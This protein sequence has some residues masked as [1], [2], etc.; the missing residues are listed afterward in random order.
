MGEFGNWVVYKI[1]RKRKATFK[2]ELSER[3]FKDH[4]ADIKDRNAG[5]FCHPESGS[6]IDPKKIYSGE[7]ED[8]AARV[9]QKAVTNWLDKKTL[10]ND[11]KYLGLPENMKGT[12]FGNLRA[13]S[14]MNLEKIRIELGELTDDEK[15]ILSIIRSVKMRF[16]HQTG[17]R[18]DKT[19]LIMMS[20]SLRQTEGRHRNHYHNN[21]LFYSVEF[22]HEFSNE[23]PLKTKQTSVDQGPIA[24]LLSKKEVESRPCLI[25][26]CDSYTRS[27]F[28][29]SFCSGFP[30]PGE[31]VRGLYKSY[32]ARTFF[33]PDH[34]LSAMGLYLIQGIRDFQKSNPSYADM[35]I[36]KI[37]TSSSENNNVQEVLNSLMEPEAKV[38]RMLKS[39]DFCK[40]QFR[41]Y[42]VSEAI[43]FQKMDEL[44]SYLNNKDDCV[45]MLAE[46]LEDEYA[47]GKCMEPVFKKI[48]SMVGREDL[49][50]IKEAYAKISK[51]SKPGK[52]ADLANYLC[53]EWNDD[54][55]ELLL[56]KG[57]VK[58]FDPIST[59]FHSYKATN[60]KELI[61]GIRK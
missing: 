49:P 35:I 54:N 40:K 14:A 57:I 24:Y 47:K 28:Y 18:L 53:Y 15:N 11:F 44:L 7:K 8:R 50:A 3:K 42:S 5:I 26:L 34:L 55:R 29:R 38:P 21:Y 52:P 51:W 25:T 10:K 2:S 16:R 20:P 56:D 17:I 59:P 60:M 33:I 30:T 58:L 32:D 46:I 13:Q 43:K 4:C 19:R 27:V 1:T 36:E 61:K 9:I 31:K 22:A 48:F 39:S 41:R 45:G 37:Y 6:S 23:E 12:A